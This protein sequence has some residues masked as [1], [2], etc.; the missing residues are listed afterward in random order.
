M[1]LSIN[2]L[3]PAPRSKKRGKRVGR[4]NASGHGTSA[5][6]GTKGQRARAGGRKGL[7]QFGVKHFVSHLPKVRGFQSLA[8][9]RQIVNVSDLVVFTQAKE[10][11]NK[12]LKAKGLIKNLT[13]P[14]KLIGQAK[15]KVALTMKVAATTV[16]AKKS[17]TEA[18]GQVVIA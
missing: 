7:G 11:T 17:I 5:T 12:M 10:I 18:G 16:G 3:K 4:G 8:E 9:Q 6:R 15:L 14:I 1:S 2:S 13:I